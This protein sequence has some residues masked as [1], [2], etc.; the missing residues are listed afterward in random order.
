MHASLGSILAVESI[1]SLSS[2]HC[3]IKLLGTGLAGW[4]GGSKEGVKRLYCLA[5]R[6]HTSYSTSYEHRHRH[7]QAT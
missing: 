1:L 6:Y 4:A 2:C 3:A 5:W 7:R